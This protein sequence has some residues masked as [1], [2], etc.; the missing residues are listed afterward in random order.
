MDD[1]SDWRCLIL[2]RLSDYGINVDNLE[3]TA[4]CTIQGIEFPISFT[5]ETMEYIADTYDSDYSQ[6][7]VDM[8]EMLNKSGGKIN[9]SNL[10]SSD[11]KIMRTLIYAMLRTGGLD[12]PPKTI[13]S[14]L[15]MNGEV[16]DIYSACMTIFASQTFQVVDLKKS[17]EPQDFQRKRI[18]KSKKKK[19]RRK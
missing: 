2:A 8:N 18:T 4:I 5:M 12:E 6:F 1:A 7:E 13:F 15:G 9:S 14:F 19:N 10:T 16:L 17:N 3:N 11:L